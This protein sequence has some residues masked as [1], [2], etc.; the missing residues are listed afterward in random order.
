MYGIIDSG[1]DITIMGGGLFQKL[2]THTH[3]RKKDFKKVDKVPRTYCQQTFHLDG[4]LDLNLT[5]N[6][7]TMITPVY[8]KFDAHDQ[9]LLSEGVCR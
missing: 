3:I 6:D 4:R 7:K 9:L 1:A 2:A 5:F 8:I